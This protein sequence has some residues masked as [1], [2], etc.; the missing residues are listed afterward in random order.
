MQELNNKPVFFNSLID[1]LCHHCSVAK[2]A[3]LLGGSIGSFSK[4]LVKET[5]IQKILWIGIDESISDFEYEHLKN[6]K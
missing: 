2:S 1:S 6:G 3:I 4:C 5:P